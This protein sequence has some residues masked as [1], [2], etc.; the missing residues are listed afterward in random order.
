MH[1]CDIRQYMTECGFLPPVE[2]TVILIL[3]LF[4]ILIPILLSIPQEDPMDLGLAEA[5]RLHAPVE[6]QEELIPMRRSP[7]FVYF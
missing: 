5:I 6:V 3:I 2:V 1:L 7:G 4:L